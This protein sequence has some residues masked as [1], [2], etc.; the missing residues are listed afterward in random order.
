VRAP[1]HHAPEYDAVVV[2]SGP[3]G[4]A[5]AA[6]A[7]HAGNRVIVF[8]AADRLGGGTRTDELTLPGFRHDVCSAIHPLAASS[9][10][11]A[12]LDLARHGLELVHP[13]I[14][15]AHPLDDGTAA[16]LDRSW[17]TT[18]ASLGDD[19]A[20]WR[21]LF[22]PHALHWAELVAE[23]SGPIVHVPRHPVVL[24][25][26]GL[27]G[28]QPATL[29]ARRRFRGVHARALFAGIAAH[30]ML[31]LG[32][33]LTS[34]F[35]LML[36]AAGHAVGWPLIRGGSERL[37]DA[38][39]AVVIEHG[40]EIVTGT[41]VQALDALPPARAYFLDTSPRD[42]VTIAG[43]RLPPRVRRALASF[44]RGPAAFKVDYALDAPVPWTSD[45]CRRAGTVHVGGTL[46][47][48]AAAEAEVA[49]GRH[50]ERP[51][52]LVAQQSLFDDTR[53]PSGR[54]TLWAYCHVPTGSTVDMSARIDAQIERFAPGFREV[55]TE[56]H[57]LAP[58]DLE[59]RNR[60]K[61]GGDI[62]GGALDGFQLV[63]R[64][65]LAADPYRLAGGVYLCSASTPPGPGVHGLCAAG[66]VARA[67]A[68]E[69]AR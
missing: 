38:L 48:I 42:A 40:G 2:G 47:E 35:G 9:P 69:L 18:L 51:F 34:S 4:L 20:R 16:V 44:R 17:D 5:A 13:D 22:E 1:E 46:E 65:R 68:R 36:G 55:V 11:F 39:A 21:R 67:R 24:A 3:N 31:P 7:A 32:R 54:H 25:R 6:L 45:A 23:L 12:P 56:R 58:A 49:R 59:R 62:S 37:A 52:V 60:N 14:A 61:S 41:R 27:Q 8:E 30:S 66:A 63:F 43:D 33:P 64:P 26:F 10:A 28:V 19:G 57:E 29:L 15:L 53:A 50:P